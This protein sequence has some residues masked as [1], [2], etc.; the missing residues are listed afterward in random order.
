MS[1]PTLL[2][3]A[4]IAGE[5]LRIAS[6]SQ[7][8]PA[9]IGGAGVGEEDREEEAEG[10][11]VWSRLPEPDLVGQRLNSLI[12][13]LPE[14]P[15]RLEAY[16]L[17]GS[18]QRL[19]AA[20][21]FMGVYSVAISHV[22]NIIVVG[23]YPD[24]GVLPRL[25][26]GQEPVISLGL[27][28]TA[29]PSFGRLVADSPLVDPRIFASL[30][31]GCSG[32]N[33]QPPYCRVIAELDYWNGFNRQTMLDENRVWLENR[34]LKWLLSWVP[35]GSLVSVDGP[36][37]STPGLFV[38]VARSLS[39]AGLSPY[40]ALKAYYALSY[41]VNVLDRGK[42]I[43][44]ALIRGIRLI[45]IVKRLERSR[46]LASALMA[47]KE[48]RKRV[49]AAGFYASRDAQLVEML[50]RAY[51]PRG[52]LGGYQ[53]PAAIGPILTVLNLGGVAASIRELAGLKNSK[54]NKLDAYQ[55][56]IRGGRNLAD[57]LE[58]RGLGRVYAQKML[59]K[60]S[61]YLYVPSPLH[62][63]I[64]LRVEIP[65]V[66]QSEY[67]VTIDGRGSIVFDKWRLHDMIEDD[68]KLLAGLVELMGYPDAAQV[69]LPI[70]LADHI[71]RRVSKHSAR[72]LYNTLRHAVGFS[73]DTHLSMAEQGAAR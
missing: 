29:T 5:L 6:T 34:A 45:G 64:L 53:A 15:S 28:Y 42:L 43:E 57:V 39:L 11:V 66:M 13:P 16:G 70:T 33:G 72:V 44:E 36:I 8:R 69:P 23:S 19:E 46:F 37:F 2:D 21:L 62:G 60:R 35:S 12:H 22:S 32:G 14:P 49:E 65:V 20:T 38:Q 71:A 26:L 30:L 9:S 3:I 31:P 7:P 24:I 50:V 61:Y 51:G 47:D 52:W 58:L 73:Y 1:T 63:R 10:K 40:T 55:P 4:G 48:W 59:V 27:G 17:D 18:S 56:A 41:L 67:G 25:E 54:D 68:L